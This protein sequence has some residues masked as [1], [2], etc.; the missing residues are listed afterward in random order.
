MI[1]A[2]RILTAVALAA[3]TAACDS[4]TGGTGGLDIGATTSPSDV[5]TFDAFVKLAAA[6]FCARA[7]VPCC[8]DEHVSQGACEADISAGLRANLRPGIDGTYSQEGAAKCIDAID[9]LSCASDDDSAVDQTCPDVVRGSGYHTK[10]PG[11]VC[12]RDNEC[13]VT[14]GGTARCEPACA[15]DGTA[16]A[17][18]CSARQ[19]APRGGACEAFPT[20]DPLTIVC[21]PDDVCTAGKCV[22]RPGPGEPCS[23]ACREG[24]QCGAGAVCVVPVPPG[25][26]CDDDHLCA[27][28][29]CDPATKRCP[30]ARHDC[31]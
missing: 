22:A 30:P 19:N 24:S 1:A 15:P 2:R 10:K 27:N 23:V 18:R 28:S 21:G 26:A 12:A 6:R 20:A 11:D 4:G 3:L 7:V 16:C 31:H 5:G 14:P 8:V 17:D 25:G 13:S 9:T 29:W